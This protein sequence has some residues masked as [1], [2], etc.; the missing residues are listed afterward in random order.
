MKSLKERRKDM[1]FKFSK[2]AQK[3]EVFSQWFSKNNVTRST[4]KT[5]PKYKPV[6][7]RTA[8]YA[9]SSLPV[10]T[11]ALNW[12]PPKIYVAPNLN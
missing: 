12:H 8:R 4:R 11:E 10:I 9:R 5:K 3:H 7:T 1:V 2:Q 6:T